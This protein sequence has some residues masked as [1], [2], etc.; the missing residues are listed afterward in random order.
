MA[1]VAVLDIGKT[2]VKASIATVEGAIVETV[3]TANAALPGPP[4]LHP[5]T[6]GLEGWFLD[7]LRSLARRHRIRAVVATAHGS[8]AALV[9]GDRQLMPMIDYDSEASAELNRR[10]SDLVGP[11]E[12]RGSPVMPG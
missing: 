6:D 12:E 4:Y 5:D 2:N 1:H 10:Y 3:S 7:Q 11:L 8:L 9:G